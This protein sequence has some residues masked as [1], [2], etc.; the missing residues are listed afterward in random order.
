MLTSGGAL[1]VFGW[2]LLVAIIALSLGGALCLVL[3]PRVEFRYAQALAEQHAQ[4][5]ADL[6][7]REAEAVSYLTVAPVAFQPVALPA[8]VDL[9]P[10]TPAP[11]TAPTQPATQPAVQPTVQ[12][13]VQPIVPA[14][15][16]AV[17]VAVQ[18]Q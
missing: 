4:A 11:F 12:P 18:Q 14:P 8:P 13:A 6:A 5:E 16:P 2:G 10:P 7:I 17:P 15:A 1:N 9:G 3:A